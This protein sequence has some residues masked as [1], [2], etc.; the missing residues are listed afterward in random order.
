MPGFPSQSCPADFGVI[1]D[2]TFFLFGDAGALPVKVDASGCLPVS[3][4]GESCERRANEAY[5]SR[6]AQDLGIP[7]SQIYPYVPPG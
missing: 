3:I 5:F 7:E 4:S 6:L 1:Y 2:L